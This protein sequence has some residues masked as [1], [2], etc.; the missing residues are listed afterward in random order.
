MEIDPKLV[1]VVPWQQYATILRYEYGAPCTR[2]RIYIL[3]VNHEVLAPE[4]TDFKAFAEAVAGQLRH[5]PEIT[6]KLCCN[7]F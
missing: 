2:R 3:M 4:A 7:D 6:W 5:E 1:C